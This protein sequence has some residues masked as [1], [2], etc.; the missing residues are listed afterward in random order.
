MIS[1]HSRKAEIAISKSSQRLDEYVCSAKTMTEQTYRNYYLRKECQK[2]FIQHQPLGGDFDVYRSRMGDTIKP[3][4]DITSPSTFSY[5]PKRKC[6]NSFP[7]LQRCNFSGQ[8]I[9]YASMSAKTNFKEIDKER[10][11]GKEVYISK[12]HIDNNVNANL[13]RVI[14]PE[15][16]AISEDYKGYLRIDPNMGYPDYVTT[17]L[18]KIGNIFMNDWSDENDTEKYLPCALISN[19][20]YDFKNTGK[21]IFKGQ[22]SKYDGILY[23]SV[24]DKDR[25]LLNVAFTQ[26]FV[27]NH[28]KLKYVAKGTIAEDLMSVRIQE[29]GFCNGNKII[30]YCPKVLKDSICITKYIYYDDK[31]RAC[32][33]T[34][35][36]LFDKNHKE[37]KNYYNILGLC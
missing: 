14:P 8:S 24:K 31:G 7:P 10:C 26:Q 16:I 34:K 23:P 29:V 5:V 13:F 19:L 25:C 18:Q 2:A 32:D 17:H 33:V 15:G 27:D 9:F 36:H 28:V 21:T 35:G 37:V 20:I 12:W 1:F 4:E 11:L 3:D 22:S 6:T 30:W